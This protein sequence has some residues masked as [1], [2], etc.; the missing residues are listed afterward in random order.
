MPLVKALVQGR[1]FTAEEIA[2]FR[3]L[4]ATAEKTATPAK[5]RGKRRR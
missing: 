1:R 5:K 3:R 4:L 2:A